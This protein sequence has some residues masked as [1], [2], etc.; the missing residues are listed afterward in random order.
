MGPDQNIEQMQ[1]DCSGPGIL[2]I[3]LDVRDIN[4]AHKWKGKRPI[5]RT[6]GKGR[7]DSTKLKLNF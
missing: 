1:L 5:A 7:K 6:D 3:Q 2:T 4:I